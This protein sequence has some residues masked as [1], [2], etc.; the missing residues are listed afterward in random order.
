M[1]L[2][3][4]AVELLNR[5]RRVLLVD[6]DLEAPGLD[7]FPM[8]L[9]RVVE[10]GLVEMVND[11]LNSTTD[12]PPNVQEY[13]YEGRFDGA[14]AQPFWIMP[15]GRQDDSYD[16]RFRSIDWQDF[17]QN[18]GGF[19]FFEDLKVQWGQ[20]VNP[21]YVLIDSRTGH[22]DI[23]GICTR[24][25]PNC[26]VAMFYPNEQNLRGLPP[27]IDDIR[28]EESGPLKKKIDLH[29]VMGNVP[30]L[31]D[32]EEIFSD[33]CTAAARALRYDQ[34]SATIHHFDSWSMLKQR[35]MLVE[36]PKSKIA[37]EYRN[38]TTAIVRGNIEDK[39]GAVSYLNQLISDIRNEGGPSVDSQLEPRL[40]QIRAVHARDADVIRRLARFR[41]TQR[42]IEEALGL[43]EQ[44]LQLN[45]R[46]SESLIGRAELLTLTGQNEPALSDLA[47]YFSLEQVSP[48]SFG[49]ATRLLLN[50]NKSRLSEML[51]SPAIPKLPWATIQDLAR[52][53]GRSYE[54]CEFGVS[55]LR[56][57]RGSNRAGVPESDFTLEL[58][59]CLIAAGRFV[60]ALS[61]IDRLG[62]FSSLSVPN[63]FNYAMAEWGA[64]GILPR[65][66]FEGFLLKIDNPESEVDVN[67]LQCFS[68]AYWATG[69]FSQRDQLFD[70]AQLLFTNAPRSSFSCWTYLYRSPKDFQ[71]DLDAMKE[72]YMAG[73]GQPA[74][75]GKRLDSFPKAP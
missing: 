9:D 42:R 64:S 46:D 69:D 59:L 18:E 27:V 49:V 19:L 7:T 24:Q 15:A 75:I 54:T 30:D 3:N 67:R 43:F 34:L 53:F 23:G 33:A 47:R 44:A 71:L 20:A 58:S 48:F 40:Q 62:G 37:G 11:Y 51:D 72:F 70:R 1:A 36:R 29:F 22:T 57:W 68:L 66:L 52:E 17:Y 21:D 8:R 31:D 45:T 14:E 61:E 73:E 5:G 35:L 63:S 56:T 32:E 55:L 38:L 60:E 10:R 28:Q 50:N 2:A 13:L 6:F 25:L 39:E 12:A 41:R 4:V 65:G 26:V 16:S 74:F